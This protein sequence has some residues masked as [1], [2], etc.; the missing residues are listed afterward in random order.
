MIVLQNAIQPYYPATICNYALKTPVA[1]SARISLRKYLIR[2]SPPR[3]KGKE[4]VWD[5][6]SS[7]GLWMDAKG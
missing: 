1:G 6:P 4:P 5:C 2:T 7:K 3:V